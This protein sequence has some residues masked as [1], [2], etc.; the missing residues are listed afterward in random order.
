VCS[1]RLTARFRI[2]TQLIVFLTFG[3]GPATHQSLGDGTLRCQGVRQE[4]KSLRNGKARISVHYMF[5]S[6]SVAV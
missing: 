3:A 2:A 6:F 4:D 5:Y 1:D